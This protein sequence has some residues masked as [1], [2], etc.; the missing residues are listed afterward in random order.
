LGIDVK[1][2]ARKKGSR[3]EGVEEI[4]DISPF[5]RG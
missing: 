4:G 5:E 2:V 1:P 3:E